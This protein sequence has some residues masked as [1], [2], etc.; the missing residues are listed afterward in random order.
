MNTR[1]LNRFMMALPVATIGA[2]LCGTAHGQLAVDPAVNVFAGTEP[3]GVAMADFTSDGSVDIATTVDDPDR[4]VLL[5]N[6]GGGSFAMGPS[7]FLP[8]S[9]SPQDLEAGDLDGDGDLDI[10]VAVR[11][12]QGSVI[13]LLNNGAGTF[14]NSGSFAVGERPR[15]MDIADHDGD[16]DLDIAVANRD[17]NNASV[18]TNNGGASFTVQTLAA[19]DEPRAAAFG[20]FD[21]DGDM[22]L[23][24]SNHDS[25]TVSVYTNNAGLFA[26]SATLSTGA[27]LR[28]EGIVAVDL[29]GDGDADIAAGAEGGGLNVALVFQS[30]KGGFSNFTTFPTG[31]MDTSGIAA[32][33]LDGDGLMD[34]ITAN[35]SSNNISMLENLGGATFGAAVTAAAGAN[36]EEI[37]TGDI[38]GDGDVDL[39]TANRNSNDVSVFVNQSTD[40]GGGG[41]PCPSDLNGDGM[42]GVADLLQLLGDWGACP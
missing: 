15:G 2:A 3:S 6:D 41:G 31:G 42:V 38:D 18:L 37:A 20:D 27:Q 22:D 16:G 9:S 35:E 26:I 10:A 17:S 40:D 11:D 1:N 23:A 7:T 21:M 24:V 39:A 28:P 30:T 8:N 12:P 4:V 14:T 34:L 29:D 25:R 19:G 13:I 5:V 33:D 32:A 36:P